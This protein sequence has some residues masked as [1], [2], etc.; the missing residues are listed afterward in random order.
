M[1]WA[2]IFFALVAVAAGAW[3]VFQSAA[4]SPSLEN[5][6]SL[7][8][9][10]GIVAVNLPTTLGEKERIGKT[11]YEAVCSACHGANGQGR[12]DIAPPLIH[13]IYE[14]SHHGDMAFVLAAK[15]G[16]PSHHW[17]F[18]NM[19]AVEGVTQADVL[20]VVAYIRLLQREN[21]IS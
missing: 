16:V 15:N 9:D 6:G 18:G 14:P 7:I 3:Y 13:K 12:K 5:K 8:L 1:K 21:G 20:N 17:N 10:D 19:P 11:A 4:V 2:A